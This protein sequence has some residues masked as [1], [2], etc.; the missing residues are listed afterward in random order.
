M[1]TDHV[2]DH[3]EFFQLCINPSPGSTKCQDRGTVTKILTYYQF[4]SQLELVS[5][6]LDLPLPT[7]QLVSL[8]VRSGRGDVRLDAGLLPAGCERFQNTAV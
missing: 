4:F 5:V 1:I 6:G 8:K 3:S 7:D 2:H